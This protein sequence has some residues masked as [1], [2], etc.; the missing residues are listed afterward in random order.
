MKTLITTMAVLLV[1]TTTAN[2]HHVSLS[3]IFAGKRFTPHDLN[4]QEE[5]NAKLS[6]S[7]P[8]ADRADTDTDE[9]VFILPDG[10]YKGFTQIKNGRGEA[11]G[12]EMTFIVYDDCDIQLVTQ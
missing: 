6:T 10:T 2:A 9:Q 4:T 5:C 8:I 3:D 7:K 1:L 11:M 12:P